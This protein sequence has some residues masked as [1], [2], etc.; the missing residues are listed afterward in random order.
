MKGD[1]DMVD[2]NEFRKKGLKKDKMMTNKLSQEDK[3]K[4][5]TN[6]VTKNRNS[7][8]LEKK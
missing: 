2:E 5:D 3:R 4:N 8:N 1:R 6:D 7:L